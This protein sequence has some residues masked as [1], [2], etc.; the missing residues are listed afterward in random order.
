[1]AKSHC[2]KSFKDDQGY[3]RY[4]RPNTEYEGTCAKVEGGN[5]SD[6][7]VQAVEQG[8]IAMIAAGSRPRPCGGTYMSSP[9]ALPHV[10]RAF[11]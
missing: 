2:G 10:K 11:S 6:V 9:Q 7:L 3:C 1:M 5:Q 4:Y 8:T